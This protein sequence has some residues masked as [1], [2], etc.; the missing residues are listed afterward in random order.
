LSPEEILF[1]SFPFL[2]WAVATWFSNDFQIF[3]HSVTCFGLFSLVLLNMLLLSNVCKRYS[4]LYFKF[5]TQNGIIAFQNLSRRK[6]LCFLYSYF[7]CSFSWY[8]V[9]FI[10]K[11]V[12]HIW[13]S[14]SIGRYLDKKFISLVIHVQIWNSI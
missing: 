1:L 8:C 4:W 13:K 6:V 5:R 12:F 14:I 2:L 9:N 7:L 10:G 11:D 3:R